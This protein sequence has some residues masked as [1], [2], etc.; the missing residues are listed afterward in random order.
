MVRARFMSRMA[1]HFL[2]GK[3]GQSL[4]DGCMACGS[5]TDGPP[6]D[7]AQ[8]YKC[9]SGYVGGSIT[10]DYFDQSDQCFEATG[11]IEQCER[12]EGWGETYEYDEFFC[13]TGL[14]IPCSVC[15]ETG[16]KP[17]EKQDGG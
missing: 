3:D 12:C 1:N 13:P 14:P 8:R 11:R 9:G 17:K 16:V 7:G 15:G 6:A 2:K 4:D 5:E 10:G